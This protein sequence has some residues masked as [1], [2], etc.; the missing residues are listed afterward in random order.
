MNVF[1]YLLG[2]NIKNLIFDKENDRVLYPSSLVEFRLFE[3]N[4]GSYMEIDDYDKD[5]YYYLERAEYD[6]LCKYNIVVPDRESGGANTINPNEFTIIIPDSVRY[7]T[8]VRRPYY[9]MRGKPVTKEQAFDIIRRTDRFFDYND[10][11][12]EPVYSLNTSINLILP[13][14]YPRG[15][16]WC[17]PDGIIGENSITG[18]YPDLKEYVEEWLSKLEAFPYLDLI[19]AV[20]KWDEIPDD[21]WK[22]VFDDDRRD[23]ELAEYDEEFYE[24]IEHG[25]WVHDKTIQILT[26]NEAVEKYKEYDALYGKDRDR[27]RDDYYDKNEIYEIDADYLRHCIEANGFNFEEALEKVPKYELKGIVGLEVE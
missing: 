24:A 1:E 6:R 17:H 15:M 27:F 25:I 16:G 2:E 21:C 3:N 11:V 22:K 4:I 5:E 7:D 12:S 13:N 8:D 14:F 26:P 19:I 20:T 23:F 18:K 10:L 9:R